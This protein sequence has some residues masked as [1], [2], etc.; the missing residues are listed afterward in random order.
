MTSSTRLERAVEQRPRARFDL[1]ERFAMLDNIERGDLF[2]NDPNFRNFVLGFDQDD[3]EREEDAELPQEMLMKICK[4][5]IG[6]SKQSCPVCLEAFQKRKLYLF[7]R[8]S[9]S[10][11]LPTSLSQSMHQILV[12]KAVS[13][14]DLQNGPSKTLLYR[15]RERKRDCRFGVP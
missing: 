10:L 5:K 11:A 14:S 1:I 8:S 12:Q 15:R 2:G 13:M 3:L 7:R 4:K 9:P 6:K